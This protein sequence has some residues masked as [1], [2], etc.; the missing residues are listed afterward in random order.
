MRDYYLIQRRKRR[1]Q[2][3][4]SYQD[5]WALVDGRYGASVGV[6]PQFPTLFTD[7]GPLPIRPPWKVAGVDYGVGINSGITLKNPFT[8]PSFPPSSDITYSS[9]AR[10]FRVNVPGLVLNGWDFGG[11]T[12]GDGGGYQIY[13]AGPLGPGD[14]TTFLNCNFK[15]GPA[16]TANNNFTLIQCQAG[17][18]TLGW[19]N[20]DDDGPNESNP[21]FPDAPVLCTREVADTQSQLILY[22]NWFQNC[23]CGHHWDS[24]ITVIEQFDLISNPGWAST[25][26]GNGGLFDGTNFAVGGTAVTSEI[27][28]SVLSFRTLIGGPPTPLGTAGGNPTPNGLC[29]ALQ[30]GSN[31]YCDL[32]DTTISYNTIFNPA[33]TAACFP[34]D[35]NAALNANGPNTNDNT[36]TYYNFVWAPGA[37]GFNHFAAQG[38]VT[39]SKYSMNVDMTTG[40]TLPPN[41][42]LPTNTNFS[43]AAPGTNGQFVGQMATVTGTATI[44]VILGPCAWVLGSGEGNVVAPA[45]YFD[46]DSNGNIIVNATGAGNLTPGTYQILVAA[47]NTSSWQATT[48]GRGILT[49]V[50]ITSS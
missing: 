39:N 23:N 31:N 44:W 43:I 3:P 40:I 49:N 20:I 34:S 33:Y 22:Y 42:T 25:A 6:S 7:Y 50:T 16:L 15:R 30:S 14:M 26:H 1:Q 41:P 4:Y 11:P 2:V 21:S 9:A 45:T 8:D 17:G 38:P 28:S 37:L 13:I 5:P 27:N 10:T 35:V 36:N 12:I 47:G 18:L 32:N 19:C 24:G 46:I 29:E 48:A